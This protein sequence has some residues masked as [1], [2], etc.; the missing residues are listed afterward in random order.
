MV[1]FDWLA[2]W[3]G[4][5]WG[6]GIIRIFTASER[7]QR[8]AA[9]AT[10]QNPWIVRLAVVVA[11][12]PGIPTA[13]VYAA[14]GWARMRLATFLLLDLVGAVLVTSAVAGLGYSLGQQAV[15]VVMRIDR[16]ASVVS[17]TM[18]TVALLIPVMK[19][20]I[21]RKPVLPEG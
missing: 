19:Q 10:E 6:A 20:L 21:R 14:A 1:K 9:R 3:A 2:W 16:Y 7:A 4:R 18:I 17:L 8:F 5:Q 11:V 13:V 15:D 12:L